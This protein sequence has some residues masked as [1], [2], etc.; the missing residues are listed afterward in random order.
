[1]TF[2]LELL[3]LAGLIVAERVLRR[4]RIRPRHLASHAHPRARARGEPARART[5]S[6]SRATR[7]GSSPRCSSGS[8]SRASAIGALGEQ[9][10]AHKLR[11][12]DGVGARGDPRAPDRHLPA[13]RDRRARAE[14]DRARSPGA[15]GARRLDAR[16]RLLRRLP[17]VRSGC[18]EESIVVP[19]PRARAGAARRRARG[20]LGGGAPHAA[21]V[22]R[23]SR[24]R[25]STRSRR[26]ST[27]SS[28]SPTRRSRT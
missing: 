8:R 3:A 11:R 26:C 19:A 1:M 2:L 21:L 15:D 18:C 24:A 9:V 23:P 17:P 7:R 16:T 10:L 4:G 20:A 13:R 6:G 28:T 14:G 12:G 27:R 5:C 22:A 25:S